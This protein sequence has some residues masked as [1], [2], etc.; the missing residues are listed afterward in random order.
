MRHNLFNKGYG[1]HKICTMKMLY[2]WSTTMRRDTNELA[3]GLLNLALLG[4]AYIILSC[5]MLVGCLGAP[6]LLPTRCQKHILSLALSWQS[7]MFIINDTV[8]R[9]A[10][11]PLDE[12]YWFRK[13][14]LFKTKQI[15]KA[16]WRELIG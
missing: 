12:K 14:G 3:Q 11:L 13:K 7:T 8:S 2:G 1:A 9:G 15:W 5:R 16:Q 4:F 6:L 10:K